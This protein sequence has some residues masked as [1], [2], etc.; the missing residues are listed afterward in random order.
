VSAILNG[1]SCIY[2]IVNGTVANLFVQSFSV[3]AGFNN[4]DTVQNEAGLTVTHRLDDRKTTLSVDGICK[5]G[6]VPTL[7][8]TLTFTT[9]TSSAYPAGTASTNFVGT[10]IKVDEKAQNKGF[11]SVSIEAVD[12]ESIT[13]AGP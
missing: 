13:P 6:T 12:Y 4:E 10:V 5:T 1:T 11:T 9:N 8:S 3:S 2:G 7:G